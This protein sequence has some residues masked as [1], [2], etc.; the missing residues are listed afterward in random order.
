MWS[1]PSPGKCREDRGGD[2]VPPSKIN[3]LMS[4]SVRLS[5]WFR[6]GRFCIKTVYEKPS[7]NVKRVSGEHPNGSQSAQKQ[8]Q[9]SQCGSG[10]NV[11]T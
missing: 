11:I 9:W 6:F 10:R 1:L 4:V 7:L 8:Q 2:A 3:Y 5:I